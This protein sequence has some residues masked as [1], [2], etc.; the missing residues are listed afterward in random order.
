MDRS[1]AYRTAWRETAQGQQWMSR[2]REKRVAWR[3]QRR[4]RQKISRAKARNMQSL[5]NFEMSK[6]ERRSLAAAFTAVERMHEWQAREQARHLEEQM[7][8]ML[9]EINADDGSNDE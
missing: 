6:R 7:D 2:K 1:M 8:C 9:H 4:E 5:S 3:V